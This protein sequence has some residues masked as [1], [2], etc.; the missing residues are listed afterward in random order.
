MIPSAGV[1]FAKLQRRSKAVT[2]LRPTPPPAVPT[3][4]GDFPDGSGVTPVPVRPLAAT[5]SARTVGGGTSNQHIVTTKLRP[6]PKTQ[7]SNQVAARTLQ[8]TARHLINSNW[9]KRAAIATGVTIVLTVIAIQVVYP[10]VAIWAINSK[11]LPR[12]ERKLGRAVTVATIDVSWGHATMHNL[13]IAGPQVGDRSAVTIDAIELDFSG[14]R[15]AFGSLKIDRAVVKQPTIYLSKS[16]VDALRGQ[17]DQK[18]KGAVVD[19]TTAPSSSSGL[20]TMLPVHLDVSQ[21]NVELEQHGKF[22]IET[23]RGAPGKQIV[24]SKIHGSVASI[25]KGGVTFDIDAISLLGVDNVAL[26]NASVST[27]VGSARLIHGSFEHLSTQPSATIYGDYP[28]SSGATWQADIASEGR[29]DALSVIANITTNEGAGS[30]P[31]SMVLKASAAELTF[32][33]DIAVAGVTI[34]QPTIVNRPMT[35]L[36]FAIGGRGRYDRT[37]RKLEVPVATLSRAGVQL[38]LSGTVQL[39]SHRTIDMRATVPPISCQTALRAIPAEFVPALV[40]Y[41]LGGTFALDVRGQID[42]EDL[43]ASSLESTGGLDGCNVVSAPVDSPTKLAKSFTHRVERSP[44]QFENIVIGSK[45]SRFIDYDSIPEYI[46]KSLISTEDPTFD[47]RRGFHAPGL[48]RALIENL[49]SG[50]LKVGGSTIPMQLAKNLFLNGERTLSRKVQEMVLA[51]HIETTIPR[52]RILEIYLNA[53]EFG[54][55]IYGL[56]EA[57]RKLFGKSIYELMPL[58]AAYFSAIVPRPRTSYSNFC[59]GKL[60]KETQSR[61]RRALNLMVNAGSITSEDWDGAVDTEIEFASLKETKEQCLVRR[62]EA[63]TQFVTR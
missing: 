35:N 4:L 49:K 28:S 9:M 51:W 52:H 26:D 3:M 61:V 53:I 22:T 55:G 29:G 36:A 30:K 42:W 45:N 43:A 12:L 47:N 24:A 14:I 31:K 60:D 11:V 40:G 18:R 23:V 10:R 34:D 33:G 46:M 1:W 7:S 27:R 37:L 50:K 38:M 57:S 25:S 63:L 39:G 6:R 48:A 16:D 56:G 41:E 2:G 19:T 58:E 13:V 17:L 32:N 20:R 21:L 59:E 62:S 54:P 5:S 8:Q 15:S 44:N